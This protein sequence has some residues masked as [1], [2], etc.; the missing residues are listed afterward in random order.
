MENCTNVLF[1]SYFFSISTGGASNALVAR[2]VNFTNG[3]YELEKILERVSFVGRSCKD[4]QQK[5]H[6]REGEPLFFC[7]SIFDWPF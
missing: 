5:Y 3:N 2:L 7:S 6:V 4:I 1:I